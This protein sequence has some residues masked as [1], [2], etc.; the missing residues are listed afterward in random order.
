MLRHAF[1]VWKVHRVHFETDERNTRSRN[2]I[3]RLGAQFEG[4]RRADRPGRDGTVRNSARYS[5]IT[6]EWPGVEARLI[7]AFRRE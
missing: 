5:I 7:E 3:A 2:A 4:I 1:E 6:A